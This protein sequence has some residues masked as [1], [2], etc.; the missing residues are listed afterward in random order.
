MFENDNNYINYEDFPIFFENFN[1]SLKKGINPG[2]FESDELCEIIDIY[3]SEKRIN[4]GKFA[5]DYALKLYPNNEDLLYELLLLL[6]DYEA[7]ND[8]LTLSE[9]YDNLSYVWSDGH[10][11]T[12]LL[13]LGM[14]ENAFQY[15]KKMKSK[16]AENKENLSIIYQAMGEAL[17]EVDLFDAS[18][19]VIDEAISI[20]GN[21]IDLLWIQLQDFVELD[22]KENVIELGNYI[23][24]INP[25]DAEIWNKLGDIYK[26]VG[27]MGKAIEAYEFAQS[28]GLKDPNNLTNTIYA[29]EKNG[30]HIKALQKAEEYLA[31]Y[32]DSYLVNL[33]AIDIC[34]EIEDWAKGVTFTKNAIISEPYVESLYLYLCKFYLKL[35]ENKK[36]INALEEGIKCTKDLN[37]E[38]KNQLNELKNNM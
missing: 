30:N 26:D 35:G 31:E 4:E 37:G 19:E 6:N 23:Q 5:I 12:A 13:H 32:S 15:F 24:N 29:Y 2:Y 16:Y 33:L 7:W 8:L 10:K 1:D 9:Q 38:L 11:L 22:S 20:V 25:M 17:Y 36:A 21:D 34:F 27:E 3:F 28:L 18:I 14:E